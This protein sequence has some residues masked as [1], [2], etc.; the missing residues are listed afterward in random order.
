MSCIA[1]RIKDGTIALGSESMSIWKMGQTCF[2]ADEGSKLVKTPE[3]TWFG[4]AGDV[5][6]G[7]VAGKII[8][9]WDKIENLDDVME[10]TDSII[11]AWADA[12]QE[13]DEDGNG[14]CDILLV[15]SG[16][17]YAILSD[18]SVSE[19]KTYWACGV[20]AEIAMGALYALA[21]LPAEQAVTVA[22]EAAIAHANG[23]G[24]QVHVVTIKQ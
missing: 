12:N 3:G 19:I 11:E 20:G 4:T 13:D 22:I 15:T 14:L 18:G 8:R 5:R 6:A 17:A 21:P 23:C 7:Q 16:K 10:L 9:S 24:G 1:V 2:K